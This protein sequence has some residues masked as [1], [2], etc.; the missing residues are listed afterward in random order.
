MFL[1]IEKMKKP[2]TGRGLR[3]NDYLLQG[4]EV[5]PTLCHNPVKYSLIG[6]VLSGC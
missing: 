3:R 5:T 1:V 6:L 4:I 2:R